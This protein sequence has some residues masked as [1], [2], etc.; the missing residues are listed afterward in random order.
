[1]HGDRD[2]ALQ[3]LV[4]AERFLD[5]D[6][7]S[8]AARELEDDSEPVRD[9]ELA[10]ADEDFFRRKAWGSVYDLGLFRVL[11][12]AL[13]RVTKPALYV[14]TGVLH[15]ITTNFTLTALRENEHGRL[16]SVDYPSYF[17][18]GPANQDGYD[19]T[20]PPGREP[21]WVI[22]EKNRSRWELLLGPSTQHLPAVIER[23]P[24]VD[25][26]LHDSEHTYETMTTE[27]ELVWDALTDDGILIA[28]NIYEND[29]WSEFCKR[30]N[31]EPL[32]FPEAIAGDDTTRFGLVRRRQ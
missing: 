23:G 28:D 6:G 8:A 10:V 5:V 9:L 3:H 22:P 13:A 1:M 30:V 16:T 31:R 12:Y 14:E 15:G 11:Q 7:L 17:A 18:E 27:F 21:G 24:P 20:L 19:D 2:L 32:L 4:A 26:F 29:A 25:I